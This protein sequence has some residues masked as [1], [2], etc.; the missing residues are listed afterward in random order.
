M[1]AVMLSSKIP[2]TSY[3]DRRLVFMP[4]SYTCSLK[5]L[6]PKKLP[7]NEKAFILS[8]KVKEMIELALLSSLR[9][10][11]HVELQQGLDPQRPQRRL[12]PH[13]HPPQE[14]NHHCLNA[15]KPFVYPQ[16]LSP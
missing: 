13:A 11:Q 2:I 4:T 3:A 16:S 8:D 7:R 14:D 5:K 6:R 15:V 10:Q 12:V 9:P 1:I